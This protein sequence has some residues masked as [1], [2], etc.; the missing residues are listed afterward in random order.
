MWCFCGNLFVRVSQFERRGWC[1]VSRYRL[2]DSPSDTTIIRRAA[3]W[4][5]IIVSLCELQ[6]YCAELRISFPRVISS[7]FRSNRIARPCS[8]TFGFGSR[9]INKILIYYIA[10]CLNAMPLRAGCNGG[11]AARLIWS[12]R[13]TPRY[14][15]LT[16]RSRSKA[17]GNDEYQSLDGKYHI[18]EC[19]GK[20]TA[21]PLRREIKRTVSQELLKERW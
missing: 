8:A 14:T 1:I 13:F 17:L 19:K 12:N 9:G 10:S 21:I 6:T 18:A 20:I 3:A 7:S 4:R 15:R 11:R 16:R 2:W 5:I